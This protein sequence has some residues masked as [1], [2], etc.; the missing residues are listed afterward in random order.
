MRSGIFST[1]RQG[2]N[3]VTASIVN[4]LRRL[5]MDVV[6]VFLSRLAFDEEPASP[7]FAFKN[8]SSNKKDA[9]SV[10]DA[11]LSAGFKLLLETKIAKGAAGIDQI[12]RHKEALGGAGHQCVVLLTPD[13]EDPT[14]GWENEAR[15]NVIWRD[16]HYLSQVIDGLFKD[17]DHILSERD[18]FLLK[19]LQAMFRD[20]GLL[21]D[22][23]RVVVVAA[24]LAYGRYKN[25][26]GQNIRAYLCQPNRKLRADYLAFYADG[27]IKPEVTEIRRELE[28]FDLNAF[29]EGRLQMKLTEEQEAAIRNC[30]D[31]SEDLK[32]REAGAKLLLKAVFLS[33]PGAAGPEPLNRSITNDLRNPETQRRYAYTQGQRYTSLNRLHEIAKGNKG[34]SAL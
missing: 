19:E 21:P 4:V 28:E 31:L 24:N 6:E 26:K 8:Q 1:Y 23:D 22:R 29:L 34:T 25:Q 18:Q 10:P 12:K 2:E 11:E 13:S 17:A 14:K 27:E 15:D 5:P 16:F 32:K 33:A 7:F 30:Y 3:R 20:E 9:K